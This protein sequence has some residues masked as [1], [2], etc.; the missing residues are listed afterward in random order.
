MY[1]V[2]TLFCS[3][4]VSTELPK[5]THHSPPTTVNKPLAQW[6]QFYSISTSTLF[7]FYLILKSNR[8]SPFFTNAFSAEPFWI[9]YAYIYHDD[10]HNWIRSFGTMALM[11]R[12]IFIL[13]VWFWSLLISL[14]AAIVCTLLWGSR[15]E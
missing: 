6:H 10:I 4:L 7:L 11:K 12:Y 13:L 9:F 15:R 1:R 3:K 5:V 14:A 2:S 8:C